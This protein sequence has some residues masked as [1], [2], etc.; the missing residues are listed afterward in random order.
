MLTTLRLAPTRS[1]SL[2][3]QAEMLPKSVLTAR[4]KS[5]RQL[6]ECLSQTRFNSHEGKGL[7]SP[8]EAA[9]PT[10]QCCGEL[11]SGGRVL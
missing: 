3:G 4:D 5:A 6:A 9:K 1:A 8:L 2:L 10:S 7:E 11:Q